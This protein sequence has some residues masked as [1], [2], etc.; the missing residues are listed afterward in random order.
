M[1][2]YEFTEA[3]RAWETIGYMSMLVSNYLR[4]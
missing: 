4:V 3:I 1:A 2:A